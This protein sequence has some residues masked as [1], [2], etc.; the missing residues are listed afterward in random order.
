MIEHNGR[1][2]IPT[3]WYS[4][5]F[6]CLS[7][8]FIYLLFIYLFICGKR[9]KAKCRLL[10]NSPF[11]S[12]LYQGF[13]LLTPQQKI[14]T[15]NQHGAL[16]AFFFDSTLPC[17]V[18]TFTFSLLL[19]N[20]ALGADNFLFVSGI[21]SDSLLFMLISLH[22]FSCLNFGFTLGEESSGT[23]ELKKCV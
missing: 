22:A 14:N 12:K 16:S 4:G 7:V 21:W 18:H 11:P 6:V 2:F 19:G 17:F 5:L 20:F 10:N 23:G 15:T 8:Y 3:A 13:S 9:Q 1:H